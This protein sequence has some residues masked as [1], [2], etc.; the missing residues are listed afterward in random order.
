MGG[1]DGLSFNLVSHSFK[2]SLGFPIP[3]TK[4]SQKASF[5][6]RCRAWLGGSTMFLPVGGRKNVIFDISV[7]FVAPLERIIL[8]KN[9]F[10]FF[11]C[12]LLM[13]RSM[14]NLLK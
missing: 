12:A 4:T 13:F 2:P 9:R 10:L 1:E 11:L 6:S 7:C 3:K 14:N 8:C 5:R